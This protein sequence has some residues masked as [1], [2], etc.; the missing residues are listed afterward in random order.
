MQVLVT[1]GAGY[2]GSVLSGMLL[3]AGYR[4]TCLDRLY[5][6]KE[7]VKELLGN[8]NYRLVQGDVRYFEPTLLEGIDAVIDMAALSNDPAGELDPEKTLSINH[9]GR[10]RVAA[11]SKKHGVK[12]YILASSCSIYGFRDAVSDEKTPPNPLTTYA[13]ANNLAENDTLKLAGPEFT[14][15]ALRQAT[16]YGSSPRMRFDIAI[17]GMVLGL[18]KNKRIPI[19]RDGTQWRPFVH[20]KDTSAAFMKMLEAEKS[21]VNGEIFNV[22]SNDQNYQIFPLAQTVASGMGVELNYDWYGSPDTRSYRINFDKITKLGFRAHHTVDEAARELYEA[23][24]KGIVQ[25]TMKTRTVEWYKHL[26]EMDRFI[27]DIKFKGGIL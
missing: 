18:F 6:G 11:L 19:M 4:V 25:D 13:K 12:R 1:G 20:V 21:L 14:A 8:K 9:L 3:D 15:T 24:E 22:G 5:F 17:N 27:S 10:A 2:I 26:I 7:P 16:V 23:L